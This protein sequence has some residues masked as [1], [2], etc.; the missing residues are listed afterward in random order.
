M[1]HIEQF[2]EERQVLARAAF[3]QRQNVLSPL[4]ADE[5]VAVLAAGGDALEVTQAPQPVRRQK[6]FEFFALQGRENRHE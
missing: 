6:G 5:E 4:Q 2:D 3:D 1:Q